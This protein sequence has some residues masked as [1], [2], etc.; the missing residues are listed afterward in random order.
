METPASYRIRVR[1]E[2]D[3]S[4]SDRLGGLTITINSAGERGPVTTLLGRLADQ[5][6][7][8]GVLNALYEL[9]LPVLSVER[10]TEEEDE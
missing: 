10:L 6:A 7:V 4:F 2:L 8:S 5:A 9:H 3:E 1:G